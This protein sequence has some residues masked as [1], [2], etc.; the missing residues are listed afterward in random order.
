VRIVSERTT[1]VRGAAVACVALLLAACGSG[2]FTAPGEQDDSDSSSPT[3]SVT[4]TEDDGDNGEGEGEGEGDGTDFSIFALPSGPRTPADVVEDDVYVPLQEGDCGEARSTLDAVWQAMKS[5]RSVLL[6]E[7][8]VSLCAGDRD[9]SRKWLDGAA[10]YGLGGMDTE[11]FVLNADGQ[12]VGTYRYDC[13]LYKSLVGALGLVSRDGVTCESGEAPAWPEVDP[14]QD[15][16]GGD[17]PETPEPGD[18]QSTEPGNGEVTESPAPDTDGTAGTEGPDG[19][20]TR[21]GTAALP[22]PAQG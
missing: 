12:D 9:A 2:A 20:G 17:A 16:R 11:F 13:E 10:A 7:A 15:P 22:A 4:E 1:Q 5:P 14:R 6:Y 18:G 21:D 19:S 3:T 8:G